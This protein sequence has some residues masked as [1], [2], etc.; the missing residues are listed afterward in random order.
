MQPK[1]NHMHYLASIVLLLAGV[2]SLP[3]PVRAAE[4]YHTCTGFIDSVP[5]TISSQGVWCLR[6]S[7]GTA[8]TSGDAITIATNNITIDCNDFKIGGLAAGSSTT[9]IGIHADDRLNITVRN[10]NIRGFRYGILISDGAGHLIEDNR[11][12]SNRSRGIYVSGDNNTVRRNR[13]YDTGGNPALNTAYGIT[14]EADVIDNL[15]SGASTGHANA[16]AFGIYMLGSGTT[17]SGNVVR[18]LVEAGTGAAY[19]I[20]A[21]ANHNVQDNLIYSEPTI[22]GYGVHG[23]GICSDNIV[24]GFSTP[25]AGCSTD[26][27]NHSGGT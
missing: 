20:E 8:V 5:A 10:C 18:G 24:Y 4:T 15:V 14:A 7:L 27:N 26:S 6:H 16:R 25:L 11:L 2:A 9:A 12:D 23:G 19:G 3:A 17:A 1:V 22:N 13:V 21:D